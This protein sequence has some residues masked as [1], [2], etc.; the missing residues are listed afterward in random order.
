MPISV[1]QPQMPTLTQ[2]V[3]ALGGFQFGQ[4]LSGQMLENER[5]RQMLG[6][7]QSALPEQLKQ[8]EAATQTAQAQAQYAQ[9]LQAA[10]AKLHQEQTQMY[11]KMSAAQLQQIQASTGLTKEQ[12]SNL[13]QKEQFTKQLFP[14][15]MQQ[16]RGAIFKDP[17]MARLFQLQLAKKMMPEALSQI[18]FGEEPSKPQADHEPMAT[19]SDLTQGAPGTGLTQ[20]QVHDNL[21][22]AFSP[23]QITPNLASDTLGH[24]ELQSNEQKGKIPVVAPK[25]FSG[26]PMQNWIAFG[27]TMSPTQKAQMGAITKGWEEQAKTEADNFDK[28]LTSAS[29]S[30]NDAVEMDKYI[31]GFTK[32]YDNSHY[33]GVTGGMVPSSGIGAI[34]AK[35]AAT[36]SLGALP[37]DFTNEQKAD[38]FARGM[39]ALLLKMIHTNRLTNYE[40]KFVGGLKLGREMT[41]EAVHSFGNFMKARTE[42]L[43]EKEQFLNAAKQKGLNS[44]DASR[45]WHKYD[46]ENEVFNF[47]TG[48]V[49]RENLGK[50][51]QYLTPAKLAEPGV[52]LPDEGETRQQMPGGTI[53]IRTPDGRMADIPAE[54][55]NKALQLGATRVQ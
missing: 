32:A 11:P 26:T 20:Q 25:T 43:Q 23:E 31:K 55:L 52:K 45:M 46:A 4:Q 30:S 27:S 18:G 24:Q 19:E 48:K 54:N 7:L 37:T 6:Y 21:N 13:M 44:Y 41:P 40:L 51:K 50:W 3:P 33:K 10:I 15:L 38:R 39:Q 1:L 22:Y 42:R 47:D 8:Q 28:S 29:D 34:A 5:Q 36:L 9:P 12:I 17:M 2:A 14:L 49:N 16:K 53:T 35:G